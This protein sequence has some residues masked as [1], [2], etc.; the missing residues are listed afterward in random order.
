MSVMLFVMMA[1]MSGVVTAF[2]GQPSSA[3]P[4]AIAYIRYLILL[5]NIIPVFCHLIYLIDFNES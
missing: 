5:S 2:S 1:I 4:V 3:G